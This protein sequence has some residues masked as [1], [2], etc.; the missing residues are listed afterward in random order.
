LKIL[1]VNASDTSGGAAIAAYHL[2]KA[3][4]IEGII[5]QYLVL[6]KFSDDYTVIG[7]SSKLEQEINRLRGGVDRLRLK[8]YKNRM[9]TVFSPAL[10]PFSKIKHKITQFDPDIVHLHWVGD[11]TINIKDLLSIKKPIVWSLHDDWVFTGGCH[12]KWQCNRYIDKCGI[13]PQLGSKITNDLSRKIWYK[14]NKVYS[15]KNELYFIGL[16]K[17]EADC[18]FKSSLLKNKPILNMPNL[19]FTDLFKPFDLNKS[20][21]LWNL[22]QNKK[23]VLFG[24]KSVVNDLNKGLSELKEAFSKLLN[25]NVEI[26]I[27]G[28][29]KPK[30]VINFG[31]PTHYLGKF[32]DEISLITLYNAA[33]VVVVPSLQEN[34]SNVIMESLSCGTPVVA[35]N[36]G[37]N[38]DLIDHKK[39]GYLATPFN[40][41]DFAMGI[42]W[43]L[44]NPHYDEI[45]KNARSKVLNEFESKIVAKQ[46]IQ[47]YTKLLS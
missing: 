24:A 39:N 8:F 17:W 47:F 10:L 26:V 7:P 19:I 23:I 35:F 1:H 44:N 34:L 32:Y 4:L 6:N 12:V 45:C 36:I 42:D 30:D 20:R 29:S 25:R 40:S 2:H 3:L 21:E 28:S 14:K 22:P 16:S 37:G 13:C 5:S 18:A 41:T 31:V 11:G 38:S 46:Y 27:F 15:K 9:K 43:L 33:D